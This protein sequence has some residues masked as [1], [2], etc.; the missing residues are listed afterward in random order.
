MHVDAAG[1]TR[2][3]VTTHTVATNTAT[4]SPALNDVAHTLL[5]LGRLMLISG[6]ATEHVQEAVTTL[7]QRF[8]CQPRFLIFSEGMLLTLQMSASSSHSGH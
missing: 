8:G 7:A 6:A 5:R 2:R 1:P 4:H 3:D